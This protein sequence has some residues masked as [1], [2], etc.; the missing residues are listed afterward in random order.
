MMT[1]I[2]WSDWNFQ[3]KLLLFL[4]TLKYQLCSHWKKS[5]P[6]V[7]NDPH[8]LHTYTIKIEVRTERKLST[9]RI[10][11]STVATRPFFSN[12]RRAREGHNKEIL[13]SKWVICFVHAQ[14]IHKSIL[15]YTNE[16]VYAYIYRRDREEE[17][18]K[19]RSCS[20]R[21][22]KGSWS[23]KSARL[24]SIAWQRER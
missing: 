16:W 22:E 20:L 1:T 18:G 4:F 17:E 24:G 2:D 23:I 21:W 11:Q 3:R 12:Q 7:L 9:C 15:M 19:D 5:T 8:M 13:S 10:D 14:H 6:R